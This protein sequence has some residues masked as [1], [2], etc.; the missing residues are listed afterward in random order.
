MD[1]LII[2]LRI[3]TILPL[4]LFITMLTGRRKIGELPVFDFLTILVLGSVVGADIAD[5]KVEHLPTVFSVII[6][7]LLHYIYS[8]IIIKNRNLGKWLTF[9][10]VVVIE[11]GDF[12]KGNMKKLKYSIDNILALLREKDVFD[13]SEV[14]FAVIESTG[15]LSVQIKSQFQPLTPSEIN[16][17]TEYKGL[18]LPLIVEGKVYKHNLQKLGLDDDWLREQ[19]SENNIHSVKEI[20]FASINSQGNL[21]ISKGL[22]K[23]RE[24]GILRH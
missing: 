15:Q 24:I 12:V 18:A 4:F 21:Y 17:D 9:E 23:P 7:M 2:F 13:I 8:I 11:N 10:P 6:I 16:L 19:L 22:E 20:F 3:I 1:Y 5:P 14:E